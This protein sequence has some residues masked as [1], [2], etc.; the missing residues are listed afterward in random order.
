MRTTFQTRTGLMVLIKEAQVGAPS[1]Q[2]RF[3]PNGVTNLCLHCDRKC[4]GSGSLRVSVGVQKN[5]GWWLLNDDEAAR[6]SLA[7]FCCLWRWQPSKSAERGR[8]RG[9]VG[10]WWNRDGKRLQARPKFEVGFAPPTL[11]AKS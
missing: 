10:N 2:G 8:G 11:I 4:R 9:A 5:R 3:Y 7:S 1:S 6:G